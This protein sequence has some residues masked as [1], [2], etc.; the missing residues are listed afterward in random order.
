MIRI[1][2]L[3]NSQPVGWVRNFL[4]KKGH[5]Y[6]FEMFRNSAQR[7]K[8]PKARSNA[9]EEDDMIAECCRAVKA[10]MNFVS[11]CVLL[12]FHF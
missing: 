3:L 9:L 4:S 8:S 1:R 11:Y 7:T 5:T 2:T 6:L 10:L 12:K